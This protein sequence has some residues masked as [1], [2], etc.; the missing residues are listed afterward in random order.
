[1][2]IEKLEALEREATGGPWLVFDPMDGIWLDDNTWFIAVHDAFGK[3]VEGD[4]PFIAAAR[5]SMPAL[6]AV[7]KAAKAFGNATFDGVDFSEYVKTRE[8]L[9]AAL[10]QLEATP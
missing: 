1:M 5:N 2:T 8:A 4:F 10:A 7:A 6:L 3:H 9:R